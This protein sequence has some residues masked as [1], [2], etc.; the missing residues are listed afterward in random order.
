M[1]SV[2]KNCDGFLS[3]SDYMNLIIFTFQMNHLICNTLQN[4]MSL[5]TLNDTHHGNLHKQKRWL[6]YF[7][8]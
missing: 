7:I 8:T 5:Q 4:L 1:V 2:Y 6:V 3:P